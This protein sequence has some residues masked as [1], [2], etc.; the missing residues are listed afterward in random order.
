[1]ASSANAGRKRTPRA[2]RIVSGTTDASGRPVDSGGRPI[3]DEIPF[4]RTDPAKPEDMSADAE[5]LWDQVVELMRNHQLL[6]PLDAAALEVACETFARW[7]D[8]VRRR[9]YQ[10]MM[11]TNS[12]GEV[13]APWIGIEERAS[14]DFRAWCAEFGI[15]PAAE[16]NLVTRSG[17]ADGSLDD[18]PY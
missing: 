12:Q 4:E 18:N 6:K 16:K 9:K 14:K 3:E 11:H 10:G 5:W 1:M 17:D 7:R 13:T 15:T 2:L 8:A